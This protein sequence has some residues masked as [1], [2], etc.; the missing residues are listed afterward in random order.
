MVRLCIL[1]CAGRHRCTK[2]AWTPPPQRCTMCCSSPPRGCSQVRRHAMGDGLWAVGCGLVGLWA[3]GPVV[4][5]ECGSGSGSKSDDL[6]MSAF[7]VIVRCLS[8]VSAASGHGTR[9]C[10]RASG[11][12]CLGVGVFAA[13]ATGGY[14][15]LG[16]WGCGSVE[17]FLWAR[18]SRIQSVGSSLSTSAISV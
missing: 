2:C 1:C 5:G 7:A 3:C 4:C 13:A 16:L 12:V 15:A 11:S 9:G 10:Q 8:S 14:G 18:D 6:T 17:P